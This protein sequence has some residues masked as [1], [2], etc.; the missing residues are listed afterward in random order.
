VINVRADDG[1]LL[2]LFQ[3]IFE[4]GYLRDR[5]PAGSSRAAVCWRIGQ[6]R[7]LRSLVELLDVHPPLGRA[8]YVY[9]AWRELVMLEVRTSAVRRALAVE[10]RRRRRFAPGLDDIERM[11][12]AELRQ[13][14]CGDALR[15]WAASGHYPGSAV[16]Y[17]RWRKASN[18]GAPTPN[19]IAAA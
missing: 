15:R 7:H 12:R 9:A 18:R 17:E 13:R 2:A 6:L 4:I 16:D 8:G 11:P 3:Q 14:R 5:A 10:I 19:T 1:P